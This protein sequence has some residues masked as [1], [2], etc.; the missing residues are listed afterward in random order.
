MAAQQ[1]AHRAASRPLRAFH[2]SLRSLGVRLDYTALA[3]SSGDAL[4]DALALPLLVPP[5]AASVKPSTAMR[6]YRQKLALADLVE[7]V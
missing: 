2:V 1:L 4:A 7:G 5:V 6:L 3:R